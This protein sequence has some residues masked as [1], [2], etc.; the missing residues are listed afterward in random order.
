MSQPPS[1]KAVQAARMF[2]VLST[3]YDAVGVDFFGPIADQLVGHLAPARGESLIDIGCGK[4]QVLIRAAEHVGQTAR[5][6]GIDVSPGMLDQARVMLDRAGL[7]RVELREMDAQDPHLDGEVFDIV[8]SSLVLFF[9]P[10]PVRALGSWRTLLAPAGRIGITTFGGRDPRWEE[11]DSVFTPYLPAGMLDARTSGAKGPFASDDGVAG[12]FRQAG[13]SSVQTWNTDVDVTLTDAAHW[14]TWT[15][16][17]GQRAMWE[18]VPADKVAA[19]Q[20]HATER[21]S[22]CIGDDG[23]IHLTQTIRTTLAGVTPGSEG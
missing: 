6:M 18:A 23:Q 22:N 21:L 1:E 14:R 11:V 20:E 13:F 15:M 2:D 8:A 9:I 17:V 4:G 19:V 5:L 12:L 3:S 16:S 7:A 10:D